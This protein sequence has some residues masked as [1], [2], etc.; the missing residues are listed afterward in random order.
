MGNDHTHFLKVMGIRA[1][2][3]Q[4]ILEHWMK[5]NIKFLIQNLK[6]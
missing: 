2:F 4:T 1:K 3:I 5:G 6:T